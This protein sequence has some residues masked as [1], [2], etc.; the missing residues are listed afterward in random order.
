M[1]LVKSSDCR[2]S[3]VMIAAVMAMSYLPVLTPA[4]R[5]VQGSISCLTSNGAYLRSSSTSSLSKPVGL[6]SLM[7]SNGLK[8]SL[9]D[10]VQTGGGQARRRGNIDYK[11]RQHSQDDGA[12]PRHAG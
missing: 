4:S 1:G 8:S 9:P 2:R 6:P 12:Q 11:R 7:N 5:P 3:L 10:F